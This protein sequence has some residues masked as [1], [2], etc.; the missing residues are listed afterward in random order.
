MNLIAD[1]PLMQGDIRKDSDALKEF[2]SIALAKELS[3][4]D[5]ATDVLRLG[6]RYLGLHCG[7][8]SYVEGDRYTILH[9][10]TESDEYKILAGDVFDLGITYCKFTLRQKKPVSFHHAAKSDIAKHPSYEALKLEAY[11][12]APTQLNN[13]LF[14]TLNFTS[15]NPRAKAFTSNELYFVQLIAEWISRELDRNYRQ[16]PSHQRHEISSSRLETSPLAVIEMTPTFEVTKWSEAAEFLLGWREEQVI[17]KAPKDWPIVNHNDLSNLVSLLSNLRNCNENGCA[18]SCDLRKNNG[19]LISTEWLLSCADMDART[20]KTVQAHILDITDRVKAE[21]ELLRKSALYQDLFQNAPD[22]YLSLE[23]SGKIISV[24]NLCNKTLGYEGAELIGTP[25]WSLIQKNDVRRIRRL[26]DVAFSGDVEELEME[27]NILKKD[28]SVIKSHQRIRIIQAKQGMPRELRIIARD[29]TERKRGQAS[30]LEHLKQQRDEIS[31][32]VQ[33]RIK[34]SLQA[35]IGMLSV[36]IASH[37]ELKPILTTSI[38][39]VHTISIVNGLIMDGKDDVDLITLLASLIEASSKLF[40]SD[41]QLN[42]QI[43]SNY[44]QMLVADEVIAV[45][46]VITELLIN[47]LKHHSEGSTDQDYIQV[48]AISN[49]DGVYIEIINTCSLKASEESSDTHI[50]MPMIKSLLPPSGVSF[51]V[52]QEG[53]LYKALLDITEPVVVAN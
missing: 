13:K 33:H 31:L 32:E 7:I 3:F 4:V 12:G 42:K 41:I 35:V 27:T 25:Y 20:C 24:N 47:A 53:G 38:A 6:C 43:D 39:Q 30:R 8:I 10:H 28:N 26:I 11:I 9:V 45:A 46:L 19:Q 40:N 21:N 16:E 48:N 2:Y 34:N 1:N 37:P 23:Q 22:M 49:D 50:G 44:I 29:I 5:Q 51:N 15:I 36:N 52:S 14:G 17:N 18:F